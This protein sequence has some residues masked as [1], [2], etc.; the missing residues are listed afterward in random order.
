MDPAIRRDLR[1]FAAS[2]PSRAQRRE[3]SERLRQLDIPVLVA[4]ASEDRL[5]P[6]EHGAMLAELLPQGQLVEI[7]DSY[8]VVPQDQ[9]AVL[10]RALTELMARTA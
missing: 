2:T 1:T 4:W 7:E 3:L 5:M 8:T 9:P 6:R 10:A